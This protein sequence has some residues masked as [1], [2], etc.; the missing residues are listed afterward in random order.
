LAGWYARRPHHVKRVGSCIRVESEE[1]AVAGWDASARLLGI[2]RYR[3]AGDVEGALRALVRGGIDLVEVTLDTPG[4][5][6]AVERGRRA[7]WSIGVGTVL[8]A[9][10]V[11]RSV[12]AGA[13]FVVSPG[14]VPGVVERA[15][16]LGVDVVPGAFTPT[17][18]IRAHT[19]GGSAV[20]LFPA[21][22]GGPSYL[23]AL[24][25]PFADVPL[26][27]TGGIAIQ[28]VSA[29]LDAGAACVGLGGALA[30][31]SPPAND[32]ELG[33]ITERAAAAVAAIA[34]RP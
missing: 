8:E 7:G 1:V 22:P 32:T 5:L 16:E 17:E 10:H 24:R 34:D 3:A 15:L 14:V 33:A 11:N 6:D 25:G 12:D 27:P 30:G 28:E 23:R 18:I 29:Y 13:A 20:K 31:E 19:M 21:S 26:V 4:A 9:D 2:V